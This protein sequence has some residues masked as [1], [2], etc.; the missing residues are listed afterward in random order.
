MKKK[1]LKE[2]IQ[3]PL[4]FHHQDIHEELDEIKNILN[5]LSFQVIE[6]KKELAELKPKPFKA[7]GCAKCGT[8]TA[9]LTS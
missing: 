7:T 1:K 4:R 3:G 8:G 5:Q 2:L 6:L 9:P